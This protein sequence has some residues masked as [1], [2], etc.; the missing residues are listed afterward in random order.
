MVAKSGAACSRWGA[1]TGC[2]PSRS[3]LGRATRPP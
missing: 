2:R 1:A 3:R